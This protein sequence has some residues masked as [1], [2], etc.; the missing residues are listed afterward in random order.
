MEIDEVLKSLKNLRKKWRRIY[1]KEQKFQKQLAEK[2]N[3]GY[4]PSCYEK[5]VGINIGNGRCTSDIDALIRKLV[6]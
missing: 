2:Y 5:S 6:Q 1:N 3:N 4:V